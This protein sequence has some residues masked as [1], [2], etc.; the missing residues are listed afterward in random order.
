MNIAPLSN[1]HYSMYQVV[2]KGLQ[3]VTLQKIKLWVLKLT[4]KLEMNR[5]TAFSFTNTTAQP[6]HPA[7]VSLAP[8]APLL[9]HT[10]TSSSNSGQQMNVKKMQKSV[11]ESNPTSKFHQSLYLNQFPP[12]TTCIYLEQ[13][14]PTAITCIHTKHCIYGD[15]HS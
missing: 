2:R 3:K 8:S 12:L 7:P 5:G 13:T 6:P 14:T 15:Y 10:F 11:N 4:F 1:K 9:R